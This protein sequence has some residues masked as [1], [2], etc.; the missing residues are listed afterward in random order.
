MIVVVPTETVVTSPAEEMLATAVFDEVH[1][2]VASAVADP[3]SAD[4]LP[5]QALSVPDITGVALTV[6]LAVFSQPLLFL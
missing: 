4:V 5:I 2:V 6:K 1:G 3:V